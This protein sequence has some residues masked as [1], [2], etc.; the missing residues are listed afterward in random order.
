MI[1]VGDSLADKL[2]RRAAEE[3][4]RVWVR[5]I[6]VGMLA[7]AWPGHALDWTP[8]Q[9]EDVVEILTTDEDGDARETKVWIVVVDAAGYVRTNDS[10]WLA[11]I[12][13]GSEVALR[14]DGSTTFV[15]ATPHDDAALRDRVEQAFVEKYGF[16][17]RVMSTF[18][19]S[20]PTV[21]EL[22]EAER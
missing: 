8:F 10:R 20:E 22:V 11:N 5:W 14:R 2:P 3:G 21:I 1:D 17:Q 12:R 4:S 7:A 16:V 13:R 18:R 15:Q 9:E 19:I 6:V